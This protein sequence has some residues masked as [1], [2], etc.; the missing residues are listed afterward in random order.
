MKETPKICCDNAQTLRILTKEV[1]KLNTAL[2]HVDIHQNWL[3]QEVQQGHI[4][5]KW[6]DTAN[7]VVNGLTRI[8]PTPRHNEVIHQLNLF[9]I[10]HHLI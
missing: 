8:L 6:I 3:R 10:H 9:D 2:R 7:M 5:V 4:Q 1:P